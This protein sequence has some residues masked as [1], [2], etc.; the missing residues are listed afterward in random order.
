VY[1]FAKLEGDLEALLLLR[2]VVAYRACQATDPRDKFYALLGLL[3]SR[4]EEDVLAFTPNYDISVQDLYKK[5]AH[6]FISEGKVHNILQQCGGHRESQGLPSWS[7][8]WSFGEVIQRISAF[9][10]GLE[11]HHK[12]RAS[13]DPS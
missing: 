2:T 8:N 3:A 13:G 5:F 7:P 6:Y 11:R 12:F 9:D 1:D 10:L 4:R